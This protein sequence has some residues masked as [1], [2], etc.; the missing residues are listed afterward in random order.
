MH[1]NREGALPIIVTNYAGVSGVQVRQHGRLAYTDGNEITIPR[2]D[3]SDPKKARCAFG[4]LAHEAAHVRYTDFEVVRRYRGQILKHALLNILEDARIERLIGEDYIGVWENLELLRSGDVQGWNKY[5]SELDEKPPLQIL[6]AFLLCYTGS[7]SQRFA[8]LRSRAALLFWKSRRA[9]RH[10][11]LSAVARLSL[12]ILKAQSTSDAA[13]IT[14]AIF[15]VLN[16]SGCFENAGTTQGGPGPRV[17]IRRG[18]NGRICGSIRPG[19]ELKEQC[20]RLEGSI[21]NCLTG[22]APGADPSS[23]AP[24]ESATAGTADVLPYTR[25]ECRAG[26]K[27]FIRRIASTAFLRRTLSQ[28]VR[29]WVDHEGAQSG[30]GRRI[31]PWKAALIRTGETKV[32]Y[33]RVREEDHSTSVHMLVDVS[34]SM[35]STDG[36]EQTRCDAACRCALSLACALENIEGIVPLC[37]FFPGFRNDVETALSQGQKASARAPYFDQKPRGSTPLAQALLHAVDAAEA[38]A[39]RR[40][41]VLVLTDGIPDSLTHAKAAVKKAEEARIECYGIGIR[42][43]FIKSLLPQSEVIQTPAELD[44]AVFSLLGRVIS[45]PQA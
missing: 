6:L 10:R 12:R 40:H 11:E 24:P 31:N 43:D 33:D 2:L 25:G 18:R 16:T 8:V 21:G 30:R 19:G 44:N 26:R 38:T 7:Y 13:A 39:C 29:A 27:A 4:Y 23:M 5:V 41:I 1:H 22:I 14:D 37:S 35:L 9:L 15:A 42:L 32:F 20:D 36:G 34:G 28:K 17:R 45:K 3:L